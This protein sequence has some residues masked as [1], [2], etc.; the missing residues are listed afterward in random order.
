MTH[1]T[2]G[3]PRDFRVSLLALAL[4]P[5]VAMTDGKPDAEP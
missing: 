4:L 1:A 2:S 3:L 5:R